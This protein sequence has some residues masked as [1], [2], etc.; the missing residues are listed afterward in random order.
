M[1]PKRLFPWIL[2]AIALGFLAVVLFSPRSPMNKKAEVLPYPTVSESP[3]ALILPLV[4][5]EGMWYSQ[6]DGTR[7]AGEVTADGHIK[8]AIVGQDGESLAY[9]DG[10]F[11]TS[12]MPGQKITSTKNKEAFVLSVDDTKDFEITNNRIKFTFKMDSIGLTKTVEMA[13]A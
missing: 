7:F 4:P 13:R 11:K 5:L 2:L 12:E 10:S 1:M 6:N 9:W 3:T 8:I